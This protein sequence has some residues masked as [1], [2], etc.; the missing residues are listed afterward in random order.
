MRLRWSCSDDRLTL[1]YAGLEAYVSREDMWTIAHRSRL[2]HLQNPLSLECRA[3][4]PDV[5]TLYMSQTTS[6]SSPPQLGDAWAGGA[7]TRA[8]RRVPRDHLPRPHQ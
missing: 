5:R 6:S 7:R 2:V 1:S 8:H 3:Y 4:E